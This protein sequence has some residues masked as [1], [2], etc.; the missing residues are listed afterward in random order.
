M[1][2]YWVIFVLGVSK[3]YGGKVCFAG[4]TEVLKWSWKFACRRSLMVE[5][6]GL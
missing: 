1:G 6:L 2:F 5:D 4:L 3:K